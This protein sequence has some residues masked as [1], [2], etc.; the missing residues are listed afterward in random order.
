MTGR[1]GFSVASPS[2]E[3]EERE[4]AGRTSG[5]LYGLGGLTLV[6]LTVLPGV[7]HAHRELL[8][9][10]AAG[11]CGWG[12]CQALVIDWNRTPW[13]L[14]H[15]SNTASLALIAVIVAS[16]GGGRS[17]A[18]VYIFLIVVPAAYFYRPAVALAY[19]LGCVLTHA[20]V[21]LYDPGALHQY[22]LPQFAIAVPSYLALGAA[23]LAGKQLMRKLRRRA[24]RLA[25]EQG[26]LRRVATAVVG[27]VSEEQFFEL[28]A[29]E[30]GALLGAGAAGIMRLHDHDATIV[31]GSWAD[32][33]GGRYSAG[34]HV[35][36]RPGSDLAQAI[37]TRRPI[38]IDDHSHGSPVSR[39]GYRC[40]VVTP[41]VV[42]GELWGAL[43]ATAP[44]PGGLGAEDERRLTEFGDLLTLAITN[45]EDR[46]R[47]A[48]QATSDALTGLSNRRALHDRLSAELAG[49]RRRKAE[50]SIALID[51]DHFKQIND[52]GGHEIGDQILVLVADTLRGLARSEDTLARLG[53][54]EFAWVLP[55]TTCEQAQLAVQRAR[56]A[57]AEIAAS[58]LTITFSAGICDSTE[59]WE[60]GELIRH[61]DAALY[62]SKRNGRD[63]VRVFGP[64][65]ATPSALN[66]GR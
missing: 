12:L 46:A 14:I 65:S 34:T 17:P 49:H 26:A 28:V 8:L 45:I 11:A 10:C 1:R 55:E 63:Q 23:T 42:A 5:A 57:V 53:G 35:P 3:R 39:L 48:S 16:T 30:A 27:G 13:W 38:R 52:L 37:S 43:A 54:D 33:P 6:L 59:T 56:L 24:E 20:L 51:I 60:P 2:L 25:A 4:L 31:M 64:G 66:T 50:L 40:S 22:F 36:I 62:S 44:Q 58:M 47:L 32:H 61:A 9:L 29:R 18:W 41:V 21:L 19:L 15:V 7:T